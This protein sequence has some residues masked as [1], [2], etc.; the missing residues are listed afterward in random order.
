MP[1]GPVGP[2][3]MN[4]TRAVAPAA[5]A[6]LATVALVAATIYE[7]V[8][9]VSVGLLAIG[10]AI[11]QSNFDIISSASTLLAAAPVGSE[12]GGGM[13]QFK[14]IITG[15]TSVSV[16]VVRTPTAA[17]IYG[18]SIIATPFAPVAA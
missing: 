16:R 17:T 9:D 7:V 3:I 1:Y 4:G 12:Q 15:V 14:F 8:V 10:V 18:A 2:S 13:K 5:A 11:D 6:V